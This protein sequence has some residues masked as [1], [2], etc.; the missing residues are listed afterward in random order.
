MTFMCS[1]LTAMTKELEKQLVSF[2]DTNG[3]ILKHIENLNE[4]GGKKGVSFDI[5][6]RASRFYYC[7][8]VIKEQLY[9]DVVGE[10]QSVSW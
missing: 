7:I 6:V 10:T 5:W 4:E 8:G 9:P 2:A 1:N 3:D